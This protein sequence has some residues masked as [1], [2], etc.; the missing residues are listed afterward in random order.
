MPWAL[1]SFPFL[2]NFRTFEGL[3]KLS[4]LPPVV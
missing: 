4:L 3:F 1:H 2:L